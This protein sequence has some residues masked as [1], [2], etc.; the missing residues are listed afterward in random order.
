[1]NAP[2]Y[3][4][5]IDGEP[6][7]VTDAQLSNAESARE[8]TLTGISKSKDHTTIPSTTNRSEHQ[9]SEVMSDIHTNEHDNIKQQ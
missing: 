5:D 3:N 6:D 7:P 1:M 4:P 9:P 2:D 8:D